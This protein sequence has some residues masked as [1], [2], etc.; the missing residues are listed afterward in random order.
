MRSW[1]PSPATWALPFLLEVLWRRDLAW[2]KWAKVWVALRH[3]GFWHLQGIGGLAHLAEG[4][5]GTP[6]MPLDLE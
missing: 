5:R 1:G 4:K 3:E 2:G 6:V